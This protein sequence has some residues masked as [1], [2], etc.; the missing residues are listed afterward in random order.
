MLAKA[1]VPEGFDDYLTTIEHALEDPRF[2]AL[3]KRTAEAAGWE[4]DDPRVAELAT[5]MAEHYLANP[6]QLKIVTG[7]QARTEPRPATA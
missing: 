3:T 6:A 2:V 1:L 7:L 4:P 5:A